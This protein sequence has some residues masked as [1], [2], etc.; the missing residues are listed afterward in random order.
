MSLIHSRD[1]S[2]HSLFTAIWGKSYQKGNLRIVYNGKMP[3]TVPAST[4]VIISSPPPPNCTALPSSPLGKKR[5][6]TSVGKH[7]CWK[8]LFCLS[9][10]HH[11]EYF[12]FWRLT[13]RPKLSTRALWRTA[14]IIISYTGQKRT[15]H[16][17]N[18]PKLI[19]IPNPTVLTPFRWLLL[20]ICTKEGLRRETGLLCCSLQYHWLILPADKSFNLPMP[21]LSS[22]FNASCL[23]RKDVAR[24]H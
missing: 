21:H 22:Q 5:N 12:L 20:Y 16:H 18:H 23:F 24:L 2:G 8:S 7:Q 10:K 15:Q 13:S 3:Q 11:L 6:K 4:T 14:V 19:S 9:W 1:S 17:Q